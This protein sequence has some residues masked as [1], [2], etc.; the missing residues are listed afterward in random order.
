MK[1]VSPFALV[2]SVA[3]LSVAPLASAQT[4]FMKDGREIVAK[5]LR[6]QG[7]TLMATIQL[8]PTQEGQAPQ[9]GEFGYPI[10]QVSRID[11]PEPAQLKIATD[12]IAAGRI[13]EAIAQLDPIVK[14][15]ESFR[16]APGSWWANAA[17]LKEEGLISDGRDK[18]AD[19]IGEEISRLASEPETVSTAKALLAGSFARH[20]D[21]ARALEICD[22]V[23][24]QSNRPETLAIAYLAAGQSHLARKEWDSAL[25]AFL[26]IP[27]FYPEERLFLPPSML[28][29][30]RAYAGL[31]DFARAKSTL[32]G[33]IATY[34]SSREARQAKAELEN[35]AKAERLASLRK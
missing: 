32:Q 21:A 6:R 13:P 15:Y 3:M 20:G 16:D 19:A 5:G 12:L 29:S 25:L 28:G 24:K 35:V 34:G 11:F 30:G 14:Y 23:I 31:E 7:D 9:T 33:V 1:Q 4:F 8:P 26:E 17:L 27:V 10:A 22:A 2:V 18:E